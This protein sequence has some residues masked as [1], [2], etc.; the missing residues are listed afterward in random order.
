MMASGVWSPVCCVLRAATTVL[1]QEHIPAD[2]T[3]TDAA[4]AETRD[5]WRRG[6]GDGGCRCREGKADRHCLS[7]LRRPSSLRVCM[8]P[9]LTMVI[10]EQLFEAD[11][12]PHGRS[13]RDL[14]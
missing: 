14:C 4:D 1:P 9:R 10:S 2:N 5:R 3:I 11:A 8:P 7:P 6:C 12:Y 13:R